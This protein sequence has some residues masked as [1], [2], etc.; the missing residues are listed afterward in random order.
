[1][2]NRNVSLPR[3]GLLLGL[4]AAGAS[5]G[6]AGCGFELRKAPVFAFKTLSV[7]GNT[8]MINQIRRELRATGSVTVLPP[9]DASKADV[10][11]EILGEDRNRIVISTNSAGLVREL[12]LQLRIRFR[13]RTPGGKDLIPAADVSQ[14]RDLSFNETNALA[15]EGEADL[16]F[17]DM[18]SDI[19]QQLMRRIA[20]VKS[21]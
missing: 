12:Q 18:Q 10:I 13:L 21:L 3:R 5:L 6:L 7:S 14:T 20:A 2:N 11:L 15:K 17:R 16:L 8:A 9:E 1:M 4:A 19:A